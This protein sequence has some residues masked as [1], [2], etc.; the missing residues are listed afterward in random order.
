MPGLNADDRLLHDA[1]AGRGLDVEPAVWEDPHYAWDETRMLV[2]RSAWDYAFRRD[3]FLE[4]ARRA[5]A[6]APMWNR[7]ELVE[8]NT[9][10]RYLCDLERRGVATVPSVV[11]ERGRN[12]DL[13]ALLAARGWR[14]AVVKAAV[15][16]AGRY[17]LRVDAATN[18][19]RAQAHLDRLLPHED[20]LLQPYVESIA[21]TGE[22]SLVV[23]DGEV[24]HAVR[25]RAKG[26]D[27]RVHS[28]HGGSETVEDPSPED[29]AV[30]EAAVAGVAP[31]LYARVDVVAA[32]DGRPWVM[33]FEVVEPELF[34]RY[35]ADAVARLA[36][37]IERE[38]ERPSHAPAAAL[39]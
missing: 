9:H 22:V 7:L 12:V 4:W 30:A 35:S 14:R 32:P 26:E 28:D 23:I 20:M 29:V 31:V 18:L 8:W 2:I 25:K 34:L 24:T 33:E 5:A 15:A 19:P 36:R 13:G 38:L 17:A 10:K 11:L 27:F 16:Q 21:V 37:S 3:A 6:A 1:L 39:S